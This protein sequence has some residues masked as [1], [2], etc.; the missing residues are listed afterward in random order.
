[1]VSRLLEGNMAKLPIDNRLKIEKAIEDGFVVQKPRSY[2]GMSKIGTECDRSIWYD[3]R[4]CTEKKITKT[5]ERLFK[6]G[7]EEEKIIRRDLLNAGVFCHS[8]QKEVR[9]A[10]GYIL[11][12]YDNILENVHDAPSTPHLGEFKTLKTSDYRALKRHG[13]YMALPIYYH[14]M[15]TYMY[16]GKLKRGLFIGVCKETDAR[17]YERL[18]PNIK[19]AKEYLSRAK[20]IVLSRCI[21][22]KK[23]KASYF[24]CKMCDHQMVCHYSEPPLKTCRTCFHSKMLGGGHLGCE[25]H[26]IILSFCQQQKSCNKYKLIETWG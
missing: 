5:Q 25:K 26:R 19:E 13:L 17:Y 7:H 6:R 8:D 18:S 14:Q 10:K 16:K 22:D 4:I 1:M 24:K 23:W 21:P 2:F 3:F 15:N 12:H 11:G 20:T 9:H